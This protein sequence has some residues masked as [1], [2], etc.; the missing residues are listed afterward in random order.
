VVSEEDDE[1][2]VDSKASNEMILQRTN[3]TRTLVKDIRKRQSHF[4]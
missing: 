2:A 1:G 3:E 4:V